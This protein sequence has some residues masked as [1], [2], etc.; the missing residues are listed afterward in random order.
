MR[1]R[2]VVPL[3]PDALRTGL[4]P[5]PVGGPACRDPTIGRHDGR[6]AKKLGSGRAAFYHGSAR[7]TTMRVVE[8]TPDLPA[9]PLPSLASLV[10]NRRYS[11]GPVHRGRQELYVTCGWMV[12]SHDEKAAGPPACL[13]RGGPLVRKAHTR[14]ALRSPYGKRRLRVGL[15][16]RQPISKPTDGLQT[17]R[18]T[19]HTCWRAKEA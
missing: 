19:D 17:L 14:R 10:S 6:P 9:T 18:Q 3:V 13:R 8:P 15:S 7:T 2:T 4:R 5:W 11:P 1:L 16:C 12:V